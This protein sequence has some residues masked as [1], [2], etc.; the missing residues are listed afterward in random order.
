MTF[1]D[2]SPKYWFKLSFFILID[3][4]ILMGEATTEQTECMMGCLEASR[5][6]SSVVVSHEKSRIFF[7]FNVT[8]E[9]QA[10][11]SQ[12]YGIP[13]TINLGNYLGVR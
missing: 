13:M 5:D 1:V 8:G 2:F 6:A 9:S 4:L 7:S 11:I 10:Q 3:D 12:M